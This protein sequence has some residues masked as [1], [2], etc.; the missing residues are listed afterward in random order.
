[1]KGPR[2]DGRR[3]D[4]W[5]RQSL[6]RAAGDI[7]APGGF[8]ERVMSQVYREALA[9]RAAPTAGAAGT[10]G[11]APAGARRMYR[12]LGLSF[13]LTAAVLGA[14]LLVP[15]AAY[16]SLVAFGERPGVRGGSVETVKSALEGAGSTVRGILGEGETR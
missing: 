5:L 15:R 7:R 14:S 10:A 11:M 9:P 4:E 3:D 1:M 12:R 2:V 16:T 8:A 6:E 13:L